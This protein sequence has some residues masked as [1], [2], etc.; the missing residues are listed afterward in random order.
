MFATDNILCRYR[1]PLK[2][3]KKEERNKKREEKKR[4][5]RKELH[6]VNGKD[7][8]QVSKLHQEEQKLLWMY[9]HNC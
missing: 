8:M 5:K 3:K 9:L 2:K 1:N 4:E 6:Q 7:S